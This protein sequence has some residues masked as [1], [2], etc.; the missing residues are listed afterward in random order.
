MAY[1]NAYNSV[2]AHL[3]SRALGHVVQVHHLNWDPYR[4]HGILRLRMHVRMH[5]ST[6]HQGAVHN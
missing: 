5:V 4:V 2:R 3:N 1:E 6:V